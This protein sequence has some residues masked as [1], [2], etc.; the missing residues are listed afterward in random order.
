MRD[1]LRSAVIVNHFRY[2][3]TETSCATSFS[4][5]SVEG[6]HSGFWN[7]AL[8]T[9]EAMLLPLSNTPRDYAWGSTTAIAELQGRVP[10]GAPEAELW[11]GAHAGS[12]AL[13]SA[14]G[15][16]ALD[17]WIATDPQRALAGATSLPFLL[18]VLA[19]AAPLSLQAHPSRA[20]AQAGFAR[21]NAAGLPADSPIR[22]YK[23]AE[24]KP[25]LI[26]ALSEEFIALC[27]FRPISATVHDLQ[28]LVDAYGDAG[29]ASA[30]ASFVDELRDR[31]RASVSRAYA[32]AV[33]YLL[34][35]AHSSV[36]VIA[37]LTAAAQTE[38]A[39]SVA[40]ST[41]ATIRTLAQAYPADP[42]I[43]IGAMLN[44]VVLDAGE[45]LFLPAGNIHAYVHGLGIELMSASDNVLR[46]GLTTKHVD[47]DELIRI[48][49]FEPLVDPRLA[50]E[51]LSGV[52]SRFEAPVDDFVLYRHHNSA[53]AGYADS[54][55]ASTVDISVA[56]VALCVA[57]EA[58]LSGA[59]G[60]LTLHRGQACFITGDEKSLRI[61]GS[62][63]IFVATSKG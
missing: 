10:S 55:A 2:K 36:H 46:G 4:L 56:G 3:H 48:A 63:D 37:Q 54:D 27:G 28:S 45:A 17:E 20:Q 5:L 32:W 16:Y 38:Q 53:A 19:A 7:L 1:P 34:R 26:V 50:P 51:Q 59:H 52:L 18:K 40:P 61:E 14:D 42:G 24:H 49:D 25:E 30:A 39:A 15:E 33:E 8:A 9:V 58:R 60:S 35:G 47:V 11:L 13:V 31:S 29:G 12:P 6:W 44:R 23:D 41:T 57:G 22:N 43:V 62:G 21:E